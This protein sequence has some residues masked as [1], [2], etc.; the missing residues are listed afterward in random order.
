MSF[1]I[2][3]PRK[4]RGRDVAKLGFTLLSV[5]LASVLVCAQDM[6]QVLREPPLN[7]NSPLIADT[8][9]CSQTESIVV[10]GAIAKRAKLKARLLNLL[11]ESLFDDAKG[12]VN[13]SREREI[14]K[15]ASQLRNDRSN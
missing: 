8:L 11:R 3:A 13:A 7:P 12:V 5:M 9:K 1:V 15:L 6:T 10:P 4:S 2:S 14:R